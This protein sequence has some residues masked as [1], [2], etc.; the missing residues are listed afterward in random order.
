[1]Q[2]RLPPPWT[3]HH[4]DDS[5]WVQDAA[6]HRFAFV[7]YRQKPIGGTDNG[8]RVSEDLARRI[9]ANVARLPDLLHSLKMVTWRQQNTK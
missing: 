5:Y 9:T 8:V 2:E 4:N 7:Y 3:V 1:M 6:G